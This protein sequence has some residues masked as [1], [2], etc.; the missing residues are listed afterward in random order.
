MNMH[1]HHHTQHQVVALI[2]EQR[3]LRE[4]FRQLEELLRPT[5]ILPSAW[6]L[7][8][9]EA[10]FLKALRATA[11]GMV[12]RDRMMIALYGLNDEAPEP[13]TLDVYLCKVRR[14]LMEAQTRIQVETIFGAPVAAPSGERRSL[15]RGRC[16]LPRLRGPR[17]R[18]EGC[19][20]ALSIYCADCG[21]ECERTSGREAG[22]RDPDLIDAEVWV[23]TVCP[24]AWAPCAADGSAISL[25]A[26]EK[27]REARAMLRERQIERRIGKALKNCPNGWPIAEERV[28][29][30]LAYELRLPFAEAAVDRLDIIWRRRAWL[31][32]KGV[33]YADVMRHAQTFR[34]R[35]AA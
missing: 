26:G 4:Q 27:T 34:P 19:M 7:T 5:I 28:A 21:T 30:F 2:E 23:C 12:H 24:G 17:I 33:S 29:S 16:R 1:A 31:V 32:L 22:A 10:G 11:P 18:P 14:R 6:R 3:T 13:K 9:R 8:C 25:P 35:K 20:S 15:R